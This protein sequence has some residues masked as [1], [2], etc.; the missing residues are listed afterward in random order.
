MAEREPLPPPVRDHL[1]RLTGRH[2]IYQH[3]GGPR[4]DRRHG[5][6]T[7]D[8]A[9]ALLVD[10]MQAA[11][12]GWHAV[13]SSAA[14]SIE[15]LED[16]FDPATGRFRN[17]RS[18]D[19]TWLDRPGSQDSHG[20]AMVG[21]AS[22]LAV[23]DR[24][25]DASSAA[26]AGRAA[27]LLERALPA[28]TGL[29]AARAVASS[30]LACC[31]ALGA[32]SSSLS[33]PGRRRA[34]AALEV[35]ARRLGAAFASASR[36]PTRPRGGAWPWPEPVVTYEGFLLPRALLAAGALLGRDD[37]LRLGGEAL[38][39]LLDGLLD[40]DD[41]FHPIGNRGWWQH[42][43]PPA[44]FDQQ[45]IEAGSMV[46][47]ADLAYEL[48]GDA[49][50][51]AAAEAGYGWF[52]GRNDLGLPVAQPL[53]GA[54]HDG[55]GPDGLNRNQGAESTLVWLA[56]VEHYRAIRARVDRTGDQRRGSTKPWGSGRGQDRTYARTAS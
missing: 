45:P 41:R 27:A 35:L 7:D 11:E 4:P 48:T 32:G 21:L 16:A 47:A 33:A 13:A 15:Y 5:T 53:T 54:C 26:L 55:L 3:A 12:L 28:A 8:V 9:R 42:L 51:V 25:V 2:G 20:R 18:D 40:Q 39:W 36:R 14:R 56:T 29:I 10:V 43:G 30:I 49:R 44:R 24:E 38:D 19:G 17:M 46:A 6:C 37:L 31:E 34:E 1:Q 22:A 23:R 50:Y 52:I